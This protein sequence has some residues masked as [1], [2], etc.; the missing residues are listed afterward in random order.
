MNEGSYTVE[1]SLIMC[2]II[3]I[4]LGIVYMGFYVY[5]YY[6]A[7]LIMTETMKRE[8]RWVIECSDRVD[9]EIHWE[10]WS[11]KSILWRL[12]YSNEGD[13]SIEQIREQLEETLLISN[14][15]QVQVNVKR[16]K[17]EVEYQLKTHFPGKWIQI[18]LGAKSLNTSN[19]MSFE[20]KESEELIRI[21]RG[22]K[23]DES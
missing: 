7:E 3:C 22:V 8:N 11:N 12:F 14:L 20:D 13:E 6:M 17:I 4:M 16:E 9:G 23:N 2:F 15:Y 1:A 19:K 5:D 18:I 10:E 21:C